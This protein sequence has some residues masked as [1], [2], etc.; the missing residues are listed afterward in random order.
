MTALHV[1]DRDGGS[2][3]AACS[4]GTVAS[5]VPRQIATGTAVFST[6]KHLHHDRA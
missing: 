3:H 5:S 2:S 1:F 6:G 4:D